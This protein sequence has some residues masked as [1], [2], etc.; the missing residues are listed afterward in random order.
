MISYP[1]I[2]KYDKVDNFYLVDFPDLEGCQTYGETLETALKSAK[3]ALTV[4]LSSL[5]ARDIKLPES[6]K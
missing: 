4:Y 5:D 3:E 6:S 2:I 1:A